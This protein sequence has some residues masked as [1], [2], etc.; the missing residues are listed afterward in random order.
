MLVQNLVRESKVFIAGVYRCNAEVMD[1][2]AQVKRETD[3]LRSAY[4]N[5]GLYYSTQLNIILMPNRVYWLY[6]FNSSA[7]LGIMARPRGNEWLTDEIIDL[8]KQNV[9][10]VI[11]LLEYHEIVELGLAREESLCKTAGIDFINFPIRDRSVPDSLHSVSSLVSSLSDLLHKGKNI[12]IHCRMGIGRSS[13]IA[14]VL[15]QKEGKRTEDV[16]EFISR[17]RGLKVPDT[18][19][20]VRWLKN[21]HGGI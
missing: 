1:W 4:R 20:Q 7:R 21:M 3:H 5:R 6:R 13:I 12:V 2:N 17:I 11:S 9:D 8:K 15:L 18:T 14:G 19:E 10:V 16:I